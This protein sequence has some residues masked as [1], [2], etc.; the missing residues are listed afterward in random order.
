MTESPP[1]IPEALATWMDDEL[2]DEWEVTEWES[3]A[4]RVTALPSD[5]DRRGLE[6][7][8]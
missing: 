5:L 4:E 8:C 2:I 6:A 1:L 3:G 7:R